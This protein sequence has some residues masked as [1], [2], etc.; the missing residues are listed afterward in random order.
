M[1]TLTSIADKIREFERR[2]IE[3]AIETDEIRRI[4]GH[5][6]V[7]RLRWSLAPQVEYVR[8]VTRLKEM[9]LRGQKED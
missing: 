8:Y 9:S 3:R 4:H 7:F 2:T 5:P 6:E 1:A